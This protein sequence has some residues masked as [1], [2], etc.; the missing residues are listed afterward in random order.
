MKRI[1]TL[2][3]SLLLVVLAGCSSGSLP[4][5]EGTLN[6]VNTELIERGT[7]VYR[8]QYCGTCHQLTAARTRGNFGPAHD[9]AYEHALERLADPDYRGKATN[10]EEYIRESIVE[11]E[12]YYTP[13]YEATNHHMPSYAHLSTEDIDLLVYLLVHQ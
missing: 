3:C 5:F 12:V 13:G 9:S 8:Q 11:P 2:L 6:T 1:Q 4:F 7:E 10:A